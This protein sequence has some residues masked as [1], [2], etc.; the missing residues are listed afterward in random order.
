[1]P[2]RLV[3]ILTF[4]CALVGVSATAA[5][6]QATLFAD[7]AAG[8]P[9]HLAAVFSGITFAAPDSEP[10]APPVRLRFDAADEAP[11]A[12]QGRPKAFEYSDGYRTRARI[13]KYASF[14]TLPLFV[15]EGFVGQSLYSNPTSGKK[16]AHLAIA[17][18]IGALFG[19]NAVTGVWNLMEARKDPNR[20]KKTLVHGIL[21]LIASGGF[22]AT[23]A[24]APESEFGEHGLNPGGEGGE[25]N[26]SLHRGIA[27]TSI[28]IAATSYLIMLFGR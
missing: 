28:G 10:G 9:D 5:Q 17:G 8:S 18:G 14:A 23:A 2:R 22:L 20:S 13:H 7:A 11:V 19:I 6:A 15:A 4:S 3:R 24:T 16:S 25:G 26:R 21:M 27:F 1:M 12:P